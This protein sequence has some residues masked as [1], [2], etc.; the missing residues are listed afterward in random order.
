[1]IDSIIVFFIETAK[2]AFIG[3]PKA[4]VGIFLLSLMWV[5]A[6]YIL[7]VTGYY[8]HSIYCWLFNKKSN[9]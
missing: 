6:F 5:L 9:V 1:M 8:I 4:I 2:I 7:G 3:I